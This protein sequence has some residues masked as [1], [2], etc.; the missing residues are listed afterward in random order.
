MIGKS[1]IRCEYIYFLQAHATDN[2]SQIETMNILGWLA[3]KK[4]LQVTKAKQMQT[5]EI[6]F[7]CVN[8]T[9]YGDY[10]IHVILLKGKF[11]AKL[12]AKLFYYI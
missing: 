3:Q 12:A 7:S 4:Q 8:R 6:N 2:K 5:D 9:Q 10:T 1:L 11:S